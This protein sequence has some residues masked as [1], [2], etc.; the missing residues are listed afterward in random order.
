MLWE[1]GGQAVSEVTRG[2]G[3]SP[4]DSLVRSAAALGCPEDG[5]KAAALLLD[6]SCVCN[7]RPLWSP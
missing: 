6:S 5:P 2:Q 3:A 4:R 1:R 7:D